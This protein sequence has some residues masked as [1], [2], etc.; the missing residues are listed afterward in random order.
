MKLS[1][2]QGPESPKQKPS[3]TAVGN[4]GCE[5]RCCCVV[6]DVVW[7]AELKGGIAV[8]DAQQGHVL[9]HV[10]VAD[11]DT[12][13]HFKAMVLVFEEVWA[14]CNAGTVHIFDAPTRR[15]KRS[16]SIHG[17]EAAAPI[18]SLFFDGLSVLG[19]SA[20]GRVVQW[21]PFTKRQ[22]AVFV[23]LAPVNAVTVAA[24]LV[25]SGD[26]DGA[27][28]LWDAHSGEVVVEHT[29]DTAGVTC[30][31]SETTTTTLW[32]GRRNGTVSVYTLAA[33]LVF[34]GRLAVGDGA[35][36]SMLAVT[37]KVLLT[38]YDRS[39]IVVAAATREVLT[40]VTVAHDAFIYGAARVYAAETLR[41]WTFGND[42]VI[43]VWDVAGYFV[44]CQSSPAL[45][46]YAQA[47]MVDGAKGALMIENA[48]LASHAAASQVRVVDV[49]EE[50]RLSRDEAHELRMRNATFEDALKAKDTEI[51]SRSSR[52]KELEEDVMRLQKSVI[53]ANTRADEALKEATM[54]RADY[55]RALQ[56]AA[57]AR[58]QTSERVAEKANVEQQLSAQRNEKSHLEIRLRD[59]E[60]EAT[61]LKAENARLHSALQQLSSSQV[62]DKDMYRKILADNE[63]VMRQEIDELRRRHQLMGALLVSMEYTIRRKEEEERDMTALLNAFR[64][65]VADRVTDP[66]LAALLNLTM[67]RNPSRFDMEC[68]EHTKSL[69]RDRNGPFIR[70][71]QQLRDRDPRTYAQ[72]VEYL[73]HPMAGNEFNSLFDKLLD[74][75][76]KESGMH[77]DDIVTFKKSLPVL[78]DSLSTMGATIDRTYSGGGFGDAQSLPTGGRQG[79]TPPP[80]TA[81]ET[82]RSAAIGLDKDVKGVTGIL[83]EGGTAASPNTVPPQQLL[84]QQQPPTAGA[85]AASL[86]AMTPD[87]EDITVF[88]R[89]MNLG[90]DGP[91][92]V[93]QTAFDS[94]EIAYVKQMQSTFE[95]ILQT[96]RDLVEQ[97][98]ILAGR[99]V[100]ARQVVDALTS[101]A[102]EV[103][104]PLHR[105]LSGSGGGR[106]SLGSVV[107]HILVELHRLV[108]GIVAAYLTAAE[109][110]RL[111][112]GA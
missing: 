54:L 1:K 102:K 93:G 11:P 66:H 6:G 56:D 21:H 99:V 38:T 3:V 98:A 25:V 22:M 91:G 61:Q 5:A 94:G 29:K 9:H 19:G 81:M 27:V 55:N 80:L 23:A 30:L 15:W 49:K 33:P 111:G 35:V 72:L 31:L 85:T 65:K 24:G 90:S 46:L 63:G 69:L 44:P 101:N 20:T 105:R 37:G 16:M 107:T 26:R 34:D 84:Q 14:G 57:Q 64:R 18:T 89:R 28:Q 39:V 88:L 74:L 43:R 4:F 78:L 2:T 76:N 106:Q 92:A 41:A 47:A 58:A 109:K 103:T 83:R 97:L 75:A 45:G 53:D 79:T 60:A 77:D 112:L 59:K 13:V 52:V 12:R 95:F 96:R 62:A 48:Q 36:T 100:K 108:S 50:L 8:C 87:E 86:R 70:F 82:N 7:V 32:V 42:G 17:V 67:V 40:R 68:D 71:L 110:Q 10:S 104:S 51:M 73:Q